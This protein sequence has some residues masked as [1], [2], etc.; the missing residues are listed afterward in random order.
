MQIDHLTIQNFNGFDHREFTFDPKFNL[1]VGDN[2]TGKSS[3]INALAVAIGSWFLGIKGYAKPIGIDADEVRLSI[4]QYQDSWSFEKQFPTQVKVRGQAMG[5]N[6]IWA[7]ELS[8]EG[9]RTHYV[10][11]RSI[12]DVAS[13]AEQRLR[14]GQ[15][16]VLPLICAYGV[17]R[18]WF[19]VGHRKIK[20]SEPSMLKRPSRFDGYRDYHAFTIQE[21]D[22]LSWIRAE[23]SAGQ[24]RGEETIAYKAFKEAVVCCVEGA[25]EPYYDERY[26]DIVITVAE[27]GHQMFRNLSDGYRIML[28]MIGDMVRR[29]AT[30]NPQLGDKVLKETSGVVLIDEL[31]LHLH[32]RWQRRVIRD[33]KETFPSIQFIATT[34]SPQLIGE[35]RPQEVIRLESKEAPNPAQAYGMDSNWVLKHIMGAEERDKTVKAKL[36]DVSG[37]IENDNLHEAQLRIDKLR[38]EIGNDPEQVRLSARIDRFAGR[39]K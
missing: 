33:L 2:A 20:T 36:D 14:D 11:A 17:E 12:S 5:R 1:L 24:Q 9:G 25:S 38:N 15:D 27:Y 7:R 32:P 23:V 39:T 28:T 18:L 37:L 26:G 29:A 30:L 21:T 22:L 6:L 4:R 13:K 3:V 8:R 10:N 34:H 31:D 19:E 16:V 35:A